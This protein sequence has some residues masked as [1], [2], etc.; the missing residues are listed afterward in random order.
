M[1]VMHD[2]AQN[3]STHGWMTRHTC[4]IPGY[5]LLFFTSR[6]TR[7]M[8]LFMWQNES[9]VVPGILLQ[10]QRDHTTTV[11]EVRCLAEKG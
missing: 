2:A 6:I 11:C 3:I 1:L 9:S 5:F 8:F 4:I 10:Q 7:I